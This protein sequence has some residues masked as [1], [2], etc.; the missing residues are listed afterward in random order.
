MALKT[1]VDVGN[2]V[3]GHV[4]QAGCDLV[5][6]LDA[7][8]RFRRDTFFGGIFHPGRVCFREI[9]PTD[10]LHVVIRGQQVSAHV[11]E[12]SPLVI[13]PDGTSRYAWGRVAAHNALVLL[14]DLSRRVRGQHGQQRC[15]LHCDIEWVD[16]DP[17]QGGVGTDGRP[18]LAS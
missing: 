11:D 13:R 1:V 5:R 2:G 16:D 7:D 4:E 8:G 10:S 6:T 15:D 18:P 12:V 17:D 14:G 3:G 9:S